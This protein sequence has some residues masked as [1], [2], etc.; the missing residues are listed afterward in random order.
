MPGKRTRNPR[1]S[2]VLS[3][4]ADGDHVWLYRWVDETGKHRGEQ[5]SSVSRCRNVT[6]AW[7]EAERLGLPAKHLGQKATA[8]AGR[9]TFGQLVGRYQK[10]AMPERFSTGHSYGSWLKLYI[11]PKWGMALIEDV[12]PALVETWLNELPLAPKS[13]GHVKG[14]MTILFNHAMKW[15]W[16]PLARNPMELVKIKG[17]VGRRRRPRVITKAQFRGLLANVNEPYVQLLIVV[18][19]CLGLRISEAIGLKWEDVDW[20]GLRLLINRGVVQGRI[21]PVKT[22]YSEAPAPLAPPLAKLLLAWR[23]KT[24]FKKPGDWIFASPFTAGEKPYF[25]TAV[26]RK[27]LAAAALTGVELHGEPTKVMRH[28]YRSW[29]GTTDTPT[30]VIKDLMRHAD[31][32]TTFNEY[33][34]GLEAPM[35]RAHAKVVRMALPARKSVQDLCKKFVNASGVIGNR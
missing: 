22:E 19:M 10:E 30:A 4:R 32:R 11:V 33:G 7:Q 15:E 6:A 18:C 34:N 17:G 12:R 28:S 21:G 8:L 20:R 26:R 13:K 25:V 29:L 23:R 31:I 27:I 24:E 9:K 5:F 3:Q 35:R 2:V 14:L 1:G 16:I